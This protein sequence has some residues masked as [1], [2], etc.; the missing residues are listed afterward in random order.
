MAKRT[1]IEEQTAKA[2]KDSPQGASE[3]SAYT[4]VEQ[5]HYEQIRQKERDVERLAT[6]AEQTKEAAS[7]AKKAFEAASSE[8]R[9]FI[10]LGPDL[11]QKLP[12]MDGEKPKEE[13]RTLS[14]ENL[15]VGV[16]VKVA[17]N[18]ALLSTLGELTDFIAKHD[19][20]WWRDLEGIGPGA[21]EKIQESYVK[22]WEQHPEYVA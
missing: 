11:Q 4:K 10:H 7:V 15:G 6:K 18:R 12:G 22:F 16:K 14:I 8:L 21:A 3:S 20:D 17:L 9:E 5:K 13:W 19:E 2:T 1:A